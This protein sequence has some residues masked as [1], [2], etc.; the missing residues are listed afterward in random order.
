MPKDVEK[1]YCQIHI[2]LNSSTMMNKF[3]GFRVEDGRGLT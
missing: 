3:R 1:H 2:N